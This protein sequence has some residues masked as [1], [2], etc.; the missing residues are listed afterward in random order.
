[1]YEQARFEEQ[2][3]IPVLQVIDYG[4]IPVKRTYPKRVFT[5]LLITLSISLLYFFFL[6]SIE[7]IRSSNN[8]KVIMIRNQIKY[9][10]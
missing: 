5:S 7:L 4:S 9:L 1:L 6:I 8:P 3:N 10:K 2:K